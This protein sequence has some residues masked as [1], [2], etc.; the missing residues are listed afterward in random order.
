M[1]PATST[2][3]RHERN[4]LRPPTNT[5][6]GLGDVGIGRRERDADVLRPLP[7]ERALAVERARND[8][9]K[10]VNRL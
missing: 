7:G 9:G 3:A 6:W 5:R 4:T 1:K 8:L 10:G 2:S